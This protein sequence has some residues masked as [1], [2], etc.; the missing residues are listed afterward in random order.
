MAHGRLVAIKMVGMAQSPRL[1]DSLK[2]AGSPSQ[3]VQTF[4]AL[5]AVNSD[6]AITHISDN[7]AQLLGL[8]RM[9][10]LGDP[11]GHW[12]RQE[13]IENFQ[14]AFADRQKGRTYLRINGLKLRDDGALYDCTL[15]TSHGARVLEFEPAQRL[16]SSP[17]CSDLSSALAHLASLSKPATL[18][19]E[20]A[21]IA[22]DHFGY[23]RAMVYRLR[24]NATSE[25]FAESYDADLAPH[26]G[27]RQIPKDHAQQ[28]RAAL[29][30]SHVC[31]IADANANPSKVESAQASLRKANFVSRAMLRA[32]PLY[33]VQHLRQMGLRGSMLLAITR[34]TRLWGVIACY[35]HDPRILPYAKC[36]D[37]ELL[38]QM[39]SVMLDCTLTKR[40]HELNLRSAALHEQLMVRLAGGSSLAKALPIIREILI[41]S[42]AHTGLSIYLRGEYNSVGCAPNAEDFEA[43][44]PALEQQ[45]GGFLF[46]CDNVAEIAREALRF[47]DMAKSALILPLE[48]NPHGY[49]ILWRQ[50]L[51]EADLWQKTS[52]HRTT[53][54]AKIWQDGASQDW[55]ADDITVAETLRT[56]LIEAAL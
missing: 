54:T 32:P 36:C 30:G 14:S 5:I 24:S 4:G 9:P 27:L 18:Y 25:V 6:W 37:A 7:C 11:L 20:V 53:R 23:D 33:Q 29:Q 35:H 49:L 50:S 15:H 44:L 52:A 41:D 31:L 51:K 1:A 17:P 46:A 26:L 45:T 42:I 10:E 48:R 3:A 13:A 21:R 39:F 16:A 28:L 12:F 34:D 2:S 22:R 40:S 55:D 56:T 47:S 43:I 19:N 8:D 38:S